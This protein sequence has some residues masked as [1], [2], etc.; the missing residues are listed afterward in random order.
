[1]NHCRQIK[2]GRV[3]IQA[4]P[5]LDRFRNLIF[6]SGFKSYA[7]Y[8]SIF[9][10]K[11]DLEYFV[12]HNGRV[13]LALLDN[14]VIIGFAVLYS[15]DKTQRWARLGGES[16]MELKA[17]EVLRGQRNRGI[18]RQLLTLLFSDAGLEEKIVYLTAY[19]W[20]WDLAC[21]G[22]SLAGYRNMLVNLYAG[23]GFTIAL[24]NDPN[25]CLKPENLF[26]VRK[27]KNVLQNVQTSF[28]WLRFGV[29]M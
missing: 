20:T 1:M 13:V 23:V 26:M 27:G 28:K 16:V 14:Q 15:P 19:S 21:S 18:A 10:R 7:C 17:V 11:E 9:T 4:N 6:S 8:T 2:K 22:L 12:A 3:H 29:S 24:T 25:I 5:P